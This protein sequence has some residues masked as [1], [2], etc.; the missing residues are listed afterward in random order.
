[1]SDPSFP[2]AVMVSGTG[3]NL[4]A[5]IDHVH[6]VE[7]HPG[8]CVLVV[9]SKAGAPALDR[10]AA[11]GIPTQVVALDDY[12]G[13]REARDVVLGDV[14]E[15]SGAELV[16]MA[17][18]MSIVTGIF[19]GRFPDQVINLHPS[20]LP[21]FAGMRAIEE[22][23]AWGV[24]MTGVTVHFAEEQVDGGPAILQEAVPV[25]Y[26][27]TVDALRERIRPVEHRLLAETVSLFAHGRVRR[28]PMRRRQVAILREEGDR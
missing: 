18:W 5:L 12:S 21:A 8:T 17:G 10:A 7:S 20:L 11:A 23:L 26:G 13:D 9:A 24:R 25:L 16:V 15:A 28:D 2:F 14:I 27:D 4:Q 3:T 6:A 22:A 19:L 1:L